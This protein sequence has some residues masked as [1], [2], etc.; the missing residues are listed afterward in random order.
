M[1]G[2]KNYQLWQDNRT[3]AGLQTYGRITELW[4]D[5]RTKA[6]LQNKRIIAELQ[7]DII[8]ELCH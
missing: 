4:Q 6:G 3:M 2:F 8:T 7:Y 1:A 5:Y